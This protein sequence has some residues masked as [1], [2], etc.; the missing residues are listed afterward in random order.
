MDIKLG[1]QLW[2]QIRGR[3]N[4]QEYTIDIEEVH[5]D[6]ISIRHTLPQFRKINFKWYFKSS[7][8]FTGHGSLMRK[9][10]DG[11]AT[12]ISNEPDWEV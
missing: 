11:T 2:Y 3:H 12:I 9:F 1:D 8:D 5:D 10:I 6:Y 7:P 4:V